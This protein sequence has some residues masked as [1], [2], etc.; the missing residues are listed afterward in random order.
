METYNKQYG[1]VMTLKEY[2][3]TRR[4]ST[5]WN[6][7]LDYLKTRHINVT[8]NK[9]H[10][11][12]HHHLAFPY[13]LDEEG[14][15]NACYF[16]SHIEI[17]SLNLWRSPQYRDFFRYLDQTGNFFYERWEDAPVHSIAAGL[18]LDTN[19]IHYFEDIGYQYHLYRHCPTKESK[20][21]CRCQCS[22]EATM[23]DHDQ[24]SKTC[25]TMWQ[26]W[27]KTDKSRKAEWNFSYLEDYIPL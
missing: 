10:H 12:H 14:N 16:S 6:S 22:E 1:F 17:A 7:V 20:L 9:H 3:D 21:G 5:L 24:N 27:I 19:Q 13:F 4:I 8:S 15:Y 23:M 25:L 18:F 26:E 11:H 2:Q